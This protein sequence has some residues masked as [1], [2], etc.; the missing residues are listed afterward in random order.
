MS[1][2]ESDNKK[3]AEKKRVTD[4]GT[5]NESVFRSAEDSFKLVSVWVCATKGKV[6]CLM[7]NECLSLLQL[8][9]SFYLSP[10]SAL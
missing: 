9:L 8:I 4:K 3:G 7:S 2:T 5:S 10:A 1:K 6:G